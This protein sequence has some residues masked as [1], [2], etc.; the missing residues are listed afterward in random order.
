MKLITLIDEYV[1][2]R[3]SLGEKFDSNTSHLRIF[4]NWMGKE[5]Q[6]AQVSRKKIIDFLYG[7]GPITSYWFIKHSVLKGLF[8]YSIARGY[9][10]KSPL[11]TEL[12]KKP[13]PFVP[14][15]YSN[16]DLKKL[17]RTALQIKTRYQDDP[18]IIWMI[19]LV[20]YAT[21]LRPNEALKLTN[22]DV[23]T[24]ENVLVIRDAKNYKSRLV[25]F[26]SQLAGIIEDYIDWREKKRILFSKRISFF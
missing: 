14:Y 7:D 9:V 16:D 22:A 2:Y 11:P 20:L 1:D 3:K 8:A 17:L 5:V 23:D 13:M 21:G 15:I 10:N 12:P 26:C 6:L 24:V 4:C 18:R 25:P 19:L